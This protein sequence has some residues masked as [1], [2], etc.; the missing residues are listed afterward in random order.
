MQIFLKSYLVILFLFQLSFYGLGQSRTDI[1]PKGEI[2][3]SLRLLKTI[4]KTVKERSSPDSLADIKVVIKN[5]TDTPASF[6]KTWNSS[7]YDAIKLQITSG[8]TLLTLHYTG[9]WAN[10]NY[11][12][13]ELLFPGDSMIFYYRI[14]CKT[15]EGCGCFVTHQKGTDVPFSG[16]KGRAI[17]A[18][19]QN[20]LL[21]HDQDISNA[22]KEGKVFP[23]FISISNRHTKK[24]SKLTLEQ[25]RRSFV[26]DKL[27]SEVSYIDFDAW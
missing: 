4:P 22:E 12:A 25:K 15:K 1:D 14:D 17:R 11:P 7:G 18:V 6:Y 3:L 19:Y 10:K 5:N 21:V 13:A 9:C 26:R 2:R 8:D 24:F 16:L 20:D 23:D 27:V